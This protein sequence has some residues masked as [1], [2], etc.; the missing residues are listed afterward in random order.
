MNYKEIVMD[1][2]KV[3]ET[4]IKCNERIMEEHFKNYDGRYYDEERERHTILETESHRAE[5]ILD[6]IL[7][8][9]KNE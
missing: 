4:T 6:I 5:I 2:K 7:K 3:C 9:G 1:I 8:G